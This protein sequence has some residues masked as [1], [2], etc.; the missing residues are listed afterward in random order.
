M[1]AVAT[2]QDG[3]VSARQLRAAGVRPDAARYAV[4]KGRLF[5]TKTGR[6][7]RVGH[8]AEAPFSQLSRALVAVRKGAVLSHRSAAMIWGLMRWDGPVEVTVPVRTRDHHGLRVHHGRPDRRRDLT[9][10]KGFPVT[11]V[12]RTLIDL[13]AVLS[14][15]RLRAVVHEAATKGWLDAATVRRLHKEMVGRRGA[16]KLRRL[17]AERDVSKGWTRSRLE[18]AFAALARDAKLPHY[19]R[20]LYVDIGG[21]DIRECDF[22]WYEQ[23]VMVELDHLPLHET[24]FVPY[25]DR[26]RDRRLTAA[27]WTVVRITGDDLKIHRDEVIRDLRRVLGCH[28]MH[29]PGQ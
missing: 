11:T 10:R 21:G 22:A 12:R 3:F 8:Q 5:R 2:R 17:L 7:Y 26:R 4:H 29:D 18:T 1:A 15:G 13:A 9:H 14:E 6:T 23:K 25:R 24:G 20:G 28:E 16:K 27:G 19:E